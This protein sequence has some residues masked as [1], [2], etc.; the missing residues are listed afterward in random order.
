MPADVL[1]VSQVTA[2]IQE[3]LGEAFPR[4]AVRG[5]I[6]NLRRQSSGHLYFSL[7]DEGAQLPCVMWRSAADRLKFRPQDGQEVVASGAIDVYP[8]HGKYQLVA[9]SLAPLGMGELHLR[10]EELKKRLAAEGLFAAERKRPLPT[11]PRRAAVVTSPTGAAVRDLLRIAFRRMPRAWITV[12]PARVQG[13]GSVE[14]VV[15]ALRLV[16]RLGEF[17]V[18]IVCRGGGSIEDLWTFNEEAVARAI[19]D[20][21]VPVVSAVGHETDTTIADFVADVRAATPSEAAE[22]VFPEFD[23]L[24]ADLAE[25]RVRLANAAT[26][27]MED[28]RRRLEALAK[29]RALAEP[30]QRLRRVA[31]DLDQWEERAALALSRRVERSRERLARV[32]GHLEAVSPLAVLGRGYSITSREGRRGALRGVEGLAAGERLVTRLAKG[33]ILSEVVDVR[34]GEP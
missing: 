22:I 8:P 27:R 16:P 13:E 30:G 10:F 31:Q 17:D 33:S 28:A 18:A 32:A 11:I 24:E 7:K 3:L 34:P 26:Q 15:G 20:C 25:R 19:A 4:V 2:V 12:F 21:P 23:A 14:D 1:S 5:Q 29:H 6:S 9:S